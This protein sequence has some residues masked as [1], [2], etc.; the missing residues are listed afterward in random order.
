M[1]THNELGKWGE[2]VAAD[3]LERNGFLIVERDWKS[4]H[5]DLD[6]VAWDGPTLVFVEVKTRQNREFGNPEWAVNYSKLRNLRLAAQHYIQYRH[7][8]QPYRFDVVTVVGQPGRTPEIEH[9]ED[10]QW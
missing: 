4:G 3:Y 5:R 7:V 6:I 8:D 2:D 1:A 10:F 9:I